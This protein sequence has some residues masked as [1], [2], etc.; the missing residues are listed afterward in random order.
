[1]GRPLQIDQKAAAAVIEA[2]GKGVPRGHAADLAGLER[3]TV[4]RWMTKGRKQ[5]DGPYRI[6]FNAMKKA[7]ADFIQRNLEKIETAG[8]DSWQAMAW[9]LERRHPEQF[10]P[11]RQEVAML[12]KQV[13]E[14]LRLV[15]GR[16][17]KASA[18]GAGH[19]PGAPGA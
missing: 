19:T 14:M 4:W 9:L 3:T 12:R 5:A 16:N 13:Q 8:A 1:M 18:G 10:G 7:E 15:E 2:T 11:Q 6:F 17:G